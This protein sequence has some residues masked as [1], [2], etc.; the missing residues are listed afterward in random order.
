M[1]PRHLVREE[2]LEVG[3]ALARSQE[4]GLQV[5]LEALQTPH[6]VGAPGA[7]GVRW[8][9]W[10]HLIRNIGLVY[11]ARKCWMAWRT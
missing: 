3:E 8:W 10:R 9:T 11:S 4:P 1:G 5:W 2:D 7:G 6:V